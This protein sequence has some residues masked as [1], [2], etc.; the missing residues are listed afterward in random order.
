MGAA[1]RQRRHRLLLAVAALAALAACGPGAHDGAPSPGPGTTAPSESSSATATTGSPL[2]TS[3]SG[4]TKVLTIVL[5]NRGAAAVTTGMPHLVTIAQNFG[6]TTHY[7]AVAHPSLPNYLALAGGSTFGVKDDGPPAAH[8]IHGSSVFDLAN[9]SGRTA[10]TYVEGMATN[11]AMSSQ[12]RYAVKHNPWVY[13]SDDASRRACAVDDV[14]LGGPTSGALADDIAA[15]ALPTVGLVV[16]DLCNDAHDCPLST[17]DTWVNAWVSRVLQGPD[18]E[19]GRLAVV[20]TFDESETDGDNTV[21]TVVV[22]PGLH[23]R[24]VDAALTHASWTRWMSDLA[25]SPA[26][27]DGAGALSLGAAFGL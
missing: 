22:A 19:A 25:G 16:P 20:I 8:P 26:P 9:A 6:Q 3:A 18:W 4:V 5:E 27:G 12:G 15:G 17:A 7:Q 11:C 10:R 14:P 2:P 24:V 23:G 1:S 21:L 13:F